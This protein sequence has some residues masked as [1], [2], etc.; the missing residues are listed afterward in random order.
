[1]GSIS[2]GSVMQEKSFWRK[3]WKNKGRSRIKISILNS[4]T[5]LAKWLNLLKRNLNLTRSSKMKRL[6]MSWWLMRVILLTWTLISKA[7]YTKR[8]SL[9]WNATWWMRKIH[10]RMT[11]SLKSDLLLCLASLDCWESCLNISSKISW[12]NWLQLLYQ[13]DWDNVNLTAERK[14]ERPCLRLSRNYHPVPQFYLWYSLTS[15]IN[16]RKVA[17]NCIHSHTLYT[18]FCIS[19]MSKNSWKP[20]IFLLS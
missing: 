7:S 2:K 3:A 19:C 13:K 18:I 10:L 17:T 16:S 8:Y 15:R 12:E 11:A 4:K 6:K 14:V 1:M 20:V 5:C 9:C